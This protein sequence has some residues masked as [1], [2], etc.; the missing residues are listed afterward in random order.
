MEWIAF[1]GSV[2]G[3]LIGGLFT[4]FGVKLTLSHQDKQKRK[5]EM[6][7]QY[8]ERPRLEL[9]DFKDFEHSSFRTKDDCDCLLL[10][11]EKISKSDGKFCFS[12][13]ERA[14][15]KKNLCSVE[16]KFVN[17]GK[18]EI[19]GVCL[20]SNHQQT[21]CLVELEYT[22]FLIENKTIFY[23]AWAKKRFIKPGDYVT[24]R[25]S[26]LK[27][28]IINP[29]ISA[30]IGLYMQDINGNLWHQPL[31]CPTKETDNSNRANYE[32][33]KRLRDVRLS[34]E[35]FDKPYLW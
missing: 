27:D 3:G 2:L 22:N 25:V 9:K 16:Y 15:D 24:I 1:A 12:Y 4:F 35:C 11:I 34:L 23:E 30:T 17:T 13:D 26:Y 33:F 7:K 8:D 10:N 18:T 28:K 32:D 6:K 21:T 14:L 31:F 29:P 20:V 19:D 5:E